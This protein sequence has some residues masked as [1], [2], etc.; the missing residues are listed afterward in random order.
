MS[1]VRALADHQIEHVAAALWTLGEEG[2]DS[3]VDMRSF[4][5]VENPDAALEQLVARGHAE[6]EGESARLTKSGRRLAERVVR[7]HR[8]AELLF[9]TVLD[10][11]DDW[12]VNR[13]AC[14][15]EHILSPAVTD[16]VCSFLGHPKA[17]PHGK[18]IPAGACCR[19]FSNAIEPLVQPLAQLGAGRSARIVYIVPRDPARLVK[20]SS[21]GLVPGATIHLEQKRPAIVIAVG[22]TT[23]ALETGIASE[24]YVKKVEQ[25]PG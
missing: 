25:P 23:L 10:V 12:T 11:G 7:R 13:T 22:E 5:R 14:L 1:H 6:H 24:I 21:L 4:S 15:M 17:C 16:S 9:S 2:N 18:P 3:I 8:L 20:L 19:T